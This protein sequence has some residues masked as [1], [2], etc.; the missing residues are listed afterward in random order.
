[1]LT[2][3]RRCH[4]HVPLAAYLTPVITAYLAAFQSGFDAGIADGSVRVSFMQSDGGL[5]G[6]QRSPTPLPHV[7]STNGAAAAAA[8][9]AAPSAAPAP[10]LAAALERTSCSSERRG[11]G[12]SVGAVCVQKS[13]RGQEPSFLGN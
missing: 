8:A 7:R 4:C 3:P 1:M 9:A 11:K 10:A 12:R 6:A 13:A 5:T 2:L